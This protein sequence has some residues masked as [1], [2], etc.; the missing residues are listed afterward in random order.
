MSKHL[1]TATAITCL[2]IFAVLSAGC[3]VDQ[4]P[5]VQARVKQYFTKFL[6]E[7]YEGCAKMLSP[8][9]ID[10]IGREG[11]I[12]RLKLLSIIAKVGNITEND[13]RIDEVTVSPDNKT[14]TTKVSVRANGEWRSIATQKWVNEAGVWYMTID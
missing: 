7:D 11:A 13:F 3:T 2:A 4:K 9:T 6:Q 1:K 8:A 14:A 5:I 12:A 10:R